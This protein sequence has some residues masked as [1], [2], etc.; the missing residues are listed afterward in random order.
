[1]VF[2]GVLEGN[3]KFCV[4]Y[5][6]PVSGYLFAGTGN[7]RAWLRV[8]NRFFKLFLAILCRARR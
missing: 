8:S 3:R 7:R 4:M 1:M 6:V 5:C 2:L